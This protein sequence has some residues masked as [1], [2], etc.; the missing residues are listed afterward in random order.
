MPSAEDLPA[1]DSFTLTPDEA[2]G[3][4][5]AQTKHYI[6]FSLRVSVLHGQGRIWPHIYI[7]SR[8][9]IPLS[10][11]KLFLYLGSGVYHAPVPMDRSFLVLLT[12]Q[13]LLVSSLGPEI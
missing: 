6:R 2:Q 7:H 12:G 13:T 10:G 5:E 9:G 4:H 8:L 11:R 1:G 3:S